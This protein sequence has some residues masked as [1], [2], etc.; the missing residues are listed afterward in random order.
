M[1]ST[2]FSDT[3]ASSLLLLDAGLRFRQDFRR[4]VQHLGLTR[5]QIA[6]LARLSMQPGLTQVDL[7]KEIEAHPVTITKIVDRLKSEGWIRRIV[8]ED[9]RRA[10]H[11]FVT[12]KAEP[13]LAE[14]WR[15]VGEL[16]GRALDGFTNSERMQF[17]RFLIRI[18]RNIAAARA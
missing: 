7:A 2:T 10:F 4:H 5:L 13:L 14:I 9:D 17:D 1:E 3:A 16:G 18:R 8:D 6:V 15:T 11:V 12:D